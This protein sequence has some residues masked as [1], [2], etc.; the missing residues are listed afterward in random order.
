M[1]RDF[2]GRRIAPVMKVLGVSFVRECGVNVVCMVHD[3]ENSS[4][5]ALNKRLGYVNGQWGYP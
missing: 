5:I 2:L 1:R 4:M 3:P